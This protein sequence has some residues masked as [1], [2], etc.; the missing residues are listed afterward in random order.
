MSCVETITYFL[1][2]GLLGVALAGCTIFVCDKIV[3]HYYKDSDES[4][5]NYTRKKRSNLYSHIEQICG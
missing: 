2:I 1:P 5:N 4:Y 3:L